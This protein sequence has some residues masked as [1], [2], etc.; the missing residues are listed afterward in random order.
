MN[1][2]HNCEDSKIRKFRLRLKE[3]IEYCVLASQ[4]LSGGWNMAAAEEVNAKQL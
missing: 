1:R 2:D 4:I 3:V